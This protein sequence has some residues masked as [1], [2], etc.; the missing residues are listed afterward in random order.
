MT[1][2]RPK[3]QYDAGTALVAADAFYTHSRSF[4]PEIGPDINVAHQKAAQNLGGLIAS[5]TM[6]ALAVELYL[7]AIRIVTGL[8]V[9]ETHDLWSLYKSLPQNLKI[10]IEALFGALLPRDTSKTAELE[11]AVWVGKA[12]S[13]SPDGW[14]E[15]SPHSKDVSVKAVLRR[16]SNAFITWRY[17][18]EGGVPGQ[19]M[20]YRYEFIRL[21]LIAQSLRK[22][23][24]ELISRQSH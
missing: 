19:Y 14:D 13:H 2:D 6:L 20:V 11:V 21:E 15:K 3:K 12:P 23:I 9:S 17:L 22:H 18:H 4:I 10:S 16:S 24:V 8:S 1:Q 5:A 7:K